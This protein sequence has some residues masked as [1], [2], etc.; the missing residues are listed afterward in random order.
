MQRE[1]EILR[2]LCTRQKM[3]PLIKCFG[4]A[5]DDESVRERHG[6]FSTVFNPSQA[7]QMLN[8]E[9]GRSRPL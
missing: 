8:Q 9:V 6:G 5:Q 3:R 7:I 4:T 2:R 1:R